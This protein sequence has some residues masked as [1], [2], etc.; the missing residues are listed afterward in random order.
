MEKKHNPIAHLLKVRRPEDIISFIEEIMSSGGKYR[1]EPVGGRRSN[2][3][4]IELANEPVPPLVERITNGIDAILERTEAEKRG[5]GQL[6]GSPRKAAEQ[7]L[8]VKKGHL[9]ALSQEQIRQ[10]AD[11][12]EISFWDSGHDKHPTVV[13]HDKGIGQHPFDLPSTI[14]S[15]GESNKIGKHYLCGAYGHGGSSTFA[16]CDYTIMISR[17]RPGH[18]NGKPD[19][20]GWTIIRKNA[21]YEDAK[22]TIYEYLVTEDKKVPT[23]QPKVLEKS[24]F[25]FG[26]YIAHIGYELDRYSGPASIVSYRLFQNRLFDPVLP[27]WLV[28]NRQ[29]PR[30]RRA[31]GGN[32]RRLHNLEEEETSSKSQVEYQNEYEENLGDDGKMLVRYWVLKVKPRAE[33]GEEKFYLDSY[34]EAPKSPRNVAITLNGQRQEF[35]DKRFIKDATKLSFLADY[36]LVQIE[37]ENLSLR[38]KKDI[39]TATRQRIRE[40]AGR[41]DLVKQVVTDA[42]KN[43]EKLKKLEEERA[44]ATLSKMDEKSEREVRGLLDRLITSPQTSIRGGVESLSAEGPGGVTKFQPKDPPTYLEIINEE[45]PIE[46]LPGVAQR[47]VLETD[48][49]D[50]TFER[51]TNRA[52]LFVNL[53]NIPNVKINRGPARSGRINIQITVPPDT[54]LDTKGVIQCSLDMDNLPSPLKTEKKDFVIVPPPP[55]FTAT[56]P[57]TLLSIAGRKESLLR[58]RRGRKTSIGIYTDAAD[59][60]L[61]RIANPA[62]FESECSVPGSSIVGRR[63]PSE[64][65]MQIRIFTPE[66]TSDGTVGTLTIKL[67]LADGKTI[68]DKRDC[69]V[70]PSPEKRPPKPRG[71]GLRQ[72]PEPNYE[73]IPVEKDDDNWVRFGWD[74]SYVGKYEPSDKLYLYVSHGYIKLVEELERRKNTSER[75]EQIGRAWRRYFAHVAYHLYLHHKY[76]QSPEPTERDQA[77]APSSSSEQQP[78]EVLKT[79]MERVSQ[80][81]LLLLRSVS[82]LTASED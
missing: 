22:T 81:I 41:L 71:G 31:L 51:K 5:S 56:E 53:S 17:R 3:N 46:F 49:P 77:P 6:P 23:I 80:T 45:E 67:R 54:S 55:P 73:I 39:F 36:L 74:E 33:G 12:V 59:D 11:N 13:I 52:S 48:G 34:L 68:E 30:F 16:W 24:G 62:I 10:L 32:L 4:D 1:F 50:D 40:G 21:E 82:D 75:P 29:E 35:L 8:G 18:N 14:L 60:T 69:V 26:T 2:S 42:L 9:D 47:I 79:E 7:W 44:E 28:D 58:L 38:R 72:R 20:I 63:G 66:T 37:C 64:G 61:I 43:D 78:E 25:E 76:Q 19:L 70:V 27:Y 57:P 65:R 15:L